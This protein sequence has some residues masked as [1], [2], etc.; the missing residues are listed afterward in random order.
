[1]RY[2]SDDLSDF[3]EVTRNT[4]KYLEYLSGASGS[5]PSKAMEFASSSWH[6]DFTDHRCPHD[7]WVESIS[8]K[9]E[10]KGGY[11]RISRVEMV[12]LCAYH[13]YRLHLEY[14]NVSHY[15]FS[16]INLES[17]HGDWVID[18]ILALR[19]KGLRHEISFSEGSVLLIESV[20]FNYWHERV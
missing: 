4:A 14:N 2:L 16:G 5:F 20:E 19:V 6:F 10:N 18:E 11:G 7:A 13:D 9:E 1:M 17:G 3:E 12:L 15:S 8:V